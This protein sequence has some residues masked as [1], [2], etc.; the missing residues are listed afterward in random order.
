MMSSPQKHERAH[1]DLLGCMYG[2]KYKP[3]R[4][5]V[6]SYAAADLIRK[7]TE[8]KS[9]KIKACQ[10]DSKTTLKFA[11]MA[12]KS[13]DD[14]IFAFI[15]YSNKALTNSSFFLLFL[16]PIFF[17]RAFNTLQAPLPRSADNNKHIARE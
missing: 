10:A 1:G 7:V 8:K 6:E 14:D 3:V 2:N 5:Y 12:A 13:N 11:K 15:S 17:W 9:S 4:P 16:R